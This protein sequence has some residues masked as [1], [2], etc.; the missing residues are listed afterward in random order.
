MADC[1]KHK[2]VWFVNRIGKEV[3]KNRLDLFNEPVLIQTKSQA[4]NLF[5]CQNDKGWRFKE[6]V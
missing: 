5:Y 6:I 2:L 4:I 1:K 3:I